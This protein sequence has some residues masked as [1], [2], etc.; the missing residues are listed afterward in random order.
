MFVQVFLCGVIMKYRNKC[1]QLQHP[2]LRKTISF[3]KLANHERLYFQKY[4]P[5]NFTQEKLYI[6]FI[7][8][9]VAAKLITELG[10]LQAINYIFIIIHPAQNS[11]TFD[12]PTRRF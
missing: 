5:A 7:S 2:D 4:V 10:L 3:N 11:H 9:V 12:S 1:G 8:V 6:M